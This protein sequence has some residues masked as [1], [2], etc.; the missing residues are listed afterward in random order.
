MAEILQ[1][2]SGSEDPD[3]AGM[4]RETLLAYLAAVQAQIEQLDAQEPED[5]MSPRYE[6]WADRH[7][8]LEDLSDEIRELLDEM[9]GLP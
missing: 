6:A 1:F 5:M 3:P 2:P 9:G 7:E 4:D 8:E